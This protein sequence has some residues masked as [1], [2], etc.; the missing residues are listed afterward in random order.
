MSRQYDTRTTI[1]SPEG[2]LFQVEYAMEAISH[3][4]TC[5]GILAKDGVLLAA[6]R[7][8]TNKLLDDVYSDKIYKLDE[9]TAC[10]VAGITS[11]ANVL[12]QKL[13]LTAQRYL[14]LYQEPMPVEQLV[15]SLCDVKQR[16][17]QVGGY[18]PFG[19]SL[20]YVGWDRR[21]GFQLYQSDPSGNY[22]GWKATC[23]GNNSM[24]AISMLKQEYNEDGITLDEAL[25]LAVKV[26]SKTLD[27]QKLT[28]EKVEIA[29]LTRQNN[30]TKIQILKNEQ[31][32]G[33]LKAH[34]EEEKKAEAEKAKA[35]KQKTAKK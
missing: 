13:R 33:L 9:D 16:Y 27:V 2:R 4:G 6:E 3:A 1:F 20:L 31:V 35:D 10:S 7:R 28:S 15:S 12:T 8:N 29:H 22:S 23:I 5:L 34:E 21:L 25:K 24:A 14:L 32:D 30:K 11:D 18:R 17:T 19:V 26:L